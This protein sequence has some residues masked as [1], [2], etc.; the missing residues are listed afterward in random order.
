MHSKWIAFLMNALL[1]NSMVESHSWETDSR[2]AAQ[3]IPRLFRE[4]RSSYVETW[5]CIIQW[6]EKIWYFRN[7]EVTVFAVTTCVQISQP[8]AAPLSPVGTFYPVYLNLFLLMWH[9]NQHAAVGDDRVYD[10]QPCSWISCRVSL[11]GLIN[12]QLDGRTDRQTDRR[13]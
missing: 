12:R 6:R 11:V 8:V 9:L 4:S 7:F 10:T 13:C 2:S 3:Y 1:T 5:K